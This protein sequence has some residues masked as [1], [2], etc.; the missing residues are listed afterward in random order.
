MELAAARG[1]GDR[2]ALSWWLPEGASRQ[3]AF[4]IVS[5]DGYD[6]GRVESD[7]QSYVDVPGFDV[8]RR[9]TAV[10]VQVWTD[11]GESDLS[12]PLE[13]HSGL[14]HPEDWI[15]AWIGVRS[16][17]MLGLTTTMS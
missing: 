2:P 9:Q 7:Q 1:R 13:L 4:R 16:Q 11:L 17:P 10:R 3:T 14:L 8:S 6:S 12:E 15:A 5:D